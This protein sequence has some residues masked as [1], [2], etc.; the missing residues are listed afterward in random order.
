MALS[1]SSRCLRWLD[2]EQASQG[3]WAMSRLRNVLALMLL[4]FAAV[5]AGRAHA[6]APV[7][8]AAL[9]QQF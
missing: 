5:A 7:A 2:Q 8:G 6:Q 3:E 4:A 9:H 1:A